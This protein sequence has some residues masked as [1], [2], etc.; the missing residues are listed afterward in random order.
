MDRPCRPKAPTSGTFSVVMF[1]DPELKAKPVR[2]QPMPDT[3]GGANWDLV[4]IGDDGK[5]SCRL[6]GAMNKVSPTPPGFWRCLTT[7]TCRAGC[8]E[9]DGETDR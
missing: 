2:Y 1:Q 4:A 3:D 5:P 8:M 7:G 6:H 9:S